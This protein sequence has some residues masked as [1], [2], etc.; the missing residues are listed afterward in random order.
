MFEPHSAKRGDGNPF[1]RFTEASVF[2]ERG[3]CVYIF[4]K[5]FDLDVM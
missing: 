4:Y 5:F 1:F 3:H 2:H